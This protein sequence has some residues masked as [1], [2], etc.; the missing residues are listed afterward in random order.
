MIMAVVKK[1]GFM[2]GFTPKL[3]NEPSV[4]EV[5]KGCSLYRYND[6]NN[7][8]QFVLFNSRGSVRNGTPEAIDL[9]KKS[10]IE[11]KYSLE[12]VREL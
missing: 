8:M 3:S 7:R 10:V 12:L 11:S 4:L 2:A 5:Y 9:I 1:G 6:T